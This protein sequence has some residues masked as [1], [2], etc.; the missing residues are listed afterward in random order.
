MS[1]VFVTDEINDS[2]TQDVLPSGAA[3]VAQSMTLLAIPSGTASGF[4]ITG[5]ILLH[6]V[7]VSETGSGIL[8]IGQT[9]NADSASAIT[10]ANSASALPHIG[11]TTRGSYLFDC[12]LN[13]G[14]ISYRLSAADTKGLSLT[15]QLL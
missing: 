11:L 12:V 13:A 1:K 14:Y 9:S 6:T 3:E 8:L 4:L 7:N 2:Y 5:A 15:Y 10:M